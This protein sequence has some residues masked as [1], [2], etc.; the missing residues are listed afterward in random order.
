[1]FLT[2]S[3]G[4]TELPDLPDA[5]FSLLLVIVLIGTTQGCIGAMVWKERTVYTAVNSQTLPGVLG[6]GGATLASTLKSF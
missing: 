1:M 2:V 6:V 5:V 4:P 3:F